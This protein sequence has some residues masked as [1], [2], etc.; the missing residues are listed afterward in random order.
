MFDK[1]IEINS[2]W[3]GT[4]IMIFKYLFSAGTVYGF[5]SFVENNNVNINV[6]MIN[7]LMEP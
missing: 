4:W 2:K 7:N 1:P 6:D 3:N 5:D